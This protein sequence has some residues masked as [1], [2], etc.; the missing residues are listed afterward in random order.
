MPG[1]HTGVAARAAPPYAEPDAINALVAL[2]ERSKPDVALDIVTGMAEALRGWSKA[3]QPAAW[4][5]A[6]SKFAANGTGELHKRAQEL[7]VVFGDG[8]AADDLRRIV[9]DANAESGPG[10]RLC[11]RC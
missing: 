8:R 6:A 2:A 10:R 11:G 4:A 7:G 9:F 1:A 3:P 5:S